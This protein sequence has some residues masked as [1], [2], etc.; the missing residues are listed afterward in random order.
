MAYI[1]TQT[2]SLLVYVYIL[3]LW[4]EKLGDFAD[5]TKCQQLPNLTTQ[6]GKYLPKDHSPLA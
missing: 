4:R 3:I 5:W 2:G 1:L 6:I